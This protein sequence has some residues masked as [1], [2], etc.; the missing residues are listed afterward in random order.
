MKTFAGVVLGL[1]LMVAGAR[2]QNA[3]TATPTAPPGPTTGYQ[4][5]EQGADWRVWQQVTRSTN[6]VSRTNQL[7]QLVRSS[8]ITTRTNQAYVEMASGLHYWRNGRWNLSQE[9]INLLPQGGAAATNGQHQVYFPGDI[10]EGAIQVVTADGTVLNSRPLGISYDDGNNT[11]FLAVLTNSTGYL[12]SSNQVVYPNAFAGIKADLLYNYTR[13]GLTQDLILRQRP[14]APEDYQMDSRNTRLQLLTEFFNPPPPQVTPSVIP[15]QGGMVLTDQALDFGRMR[16]VPGGAFLMGSAAEDPGVRV[17]KNWVS[18]GGRQF[19]VEEVPVMA[20]AREL[21]Q[22]PLVAVQSR[23]PGGALWASSQRHWPAQRP[24]GRSS[25]PVLIARNDVKATPGLVLDYNFLNSNQNNYTFAG[26]STYYLSGNV[27][28]TGTSATFEGGAVLK[29]A[30]NVTLHVEAAV[31]WLASSYQPVVMVAK[32]DNSVGAVINGSTGNPG[33]NQYAA[34]ALFYDTTYLYARTNL[35][36]AHLRVA[37]AQTAVAFNGRTNHV[38]K[39]VQLVNCGIGVAATNATFALY[40]ALLWKVQTNFAGSSATGDIEQVTVDT[41]N[42]LNPNLTLNLTNCVLVGVANF[43][44]YTAQNVNT[45][46]GGAGVF[47]QVGAGW[48]YLAAGSGLQQAGTGTINTN[49]AKELA[50]LTTWPPLMVATNFAMSGSSSPTN[51][52]PQAFRDASP[53]PDLGYH[54]DPLDYVWTNKTVGTGVTLTLTNGVAIGY[55]GSYCL[56][57]GQQN[58]VVSQGTPNQMNHLVPYQ[59]V[60][61]QAQGAGNGLFAG[62]V[63]PVSIY[64]RF[65]D[66]PMLGGAGCSYF[67]GASY[68]DQSGWFD[69]MTLQDCSLRDGSLWLNPF[70]THET[71]GNNAAPTA[72]TLGLTNNLFQR[73]NVS[74]SREPNWVVNYE[75]GAS[76][77][78]GSGNLLTPF[79]LWLC[80][81]LFWNGTVGF[82]YFSGAMYGQTYPVSSPPGWYLLTGFAC[83][84]VLEL[85]PV[86]SIY[87]NLF[88]GVTPSLGVGADNSEGNINLVEANDAFY[89]SSSSWLANGYEMG[90]QTTNN[91]TVTSL[92]FATSFLGSWYLK[93]SSPNLINHGDVTADQRAMYHY[94]MQTNQIPETNSIVDIGFHYVATDQ[95]GNPLSNYWPGIPDYLTDVNGNGT[96]TSWVAWELLY[97]GQLGLNP[98][99]TDSAGNTLQSDYQNALANNI[100]AFTLGV[101]NNYVATSTTSVQLAITAG[102]P[103]YYAVSVDDTNFATDAAWRNFTSTNI[104]VNLGLTQ[105]WHDVWI[106]LV[107]PAP[108]ATVTWQW[109]RLKLDTTPPVLVVTNPVAGATVSVPLVQVS[110]YCPEPLGSLSYDLSNGLGLVTNQDAGVTSQYYDPV[111]STFTTN[112]FECVDVPLTNGVN[113]ITLHATDLAGNMSTTSFNVTLDYS[114]RT[115]P[116]VV[117]LYWPQNGSVLGNT[118][119]TWRG[120]VDDPTATVS[121]QLVDTNGNTNV[122]AGVVER[123]GN[124]WVENLPVTGGANTLTLTVTDSAGN[125]AQTN[126]VVYP[127]AVGLTLTLPDANQW[128]NPTVTVSGTISDAA[129]Y[130]V[131][132]NGV[133]ATYGD[134]GVSWTAANVPLPPGGTALVQARAIPNTDNGGQGVGGSGGGSA[135]N[136]NLG[137]PSSSQAKDIE[138]QADKQPRLYMSY[139]EED[140][141]GS[142][143][144]S[145]GDSTCTESYQLTATNGYTWRDMI[146]GS[147]GSEHLISQLNVDCAGGSNLPS[148]Y[149]TLASPPSPWESLLPGTNYVISIADQHASG[150]SVDQTNTYQASWQS[151]TPWE[152]C[153][154][155]LPVNSTVGWPYQWVGSGYPEDP[156]NTGNY[157]RHADATLTLQTG[158]KAVVQRKN[159]F[160]LNGTAAGVLDPHTYAEYYDEV[161][162]LYGGYGNYP[163]VGTVPLQTQSV[164]VDGVFLGSDG[165]LWRVYD[166]NDTRDVTPRVVN[167]DFYEFN[168]TQQ[169]YKLSINFGGQNV[170]DN[171]STVIVGQFINPVCGWV[172]GSGPTITNYSW[173]VPGDTFSNYLANANVGKL[174]IQLCLTNNEVDFY[175]KDAGSVQV[176][177]IINA[178]GQ[179][180]SAH[181]TFAVLRPNA[182]IQAI[183]NGSISIASINGHYQLCLGQQTPDNEGVL[184]GGTIDVPPNFT[185]NSEWI[186][187][188]SFSESEQTNDGTGVWYQLGPSD[189][190]LDTFYPYP[191]DTTFTMAT[192]FATATTDSPTSRPLDNYIA[193]NRQDNMQMWLMYK[194]NGGQWVPLRKVNWGWNGSGTLSGGGWHLSVNQPSPNV[195]ND[196]DTKQ[197]PEWTTNVTGYFPQP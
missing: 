179:S 114:T 168:L 73:C 57:L 20:V 75:G 26:N 137:N 148:L 172:G 133:Q 185:L 181:T 108:G 103:G 95:Y 163:F 69:Q 138:A 192:A 188:V 81:N 28:L 159:L 175:W 113:T 158:G 129:D 101:T 37:N 120:W 34:T 42:W 97:Y 70:N 187:L 68:L 121:A 15:A 186:Q 194:P 146:G 50:N 189:N 132:V 86:W 62:G 21:L 43:G 27:A 24:A 118:S 152:H 151:A 30:S 18:A 196:T 167:N 13:E 164:K 130:T 54:Y 52:G 67:D 31:T 55:Y 56:T 78:G 116:P 29:F 149:S 171:N 47:T 170:T 87:D 174:F 110:G 49:L 178:M 165:N 92:T 5:G 48:H 38:L 115:Q 74:L 197:P 11:V 66:L 94:T 53:T 145:F 160:Q 63:S 109:K 40:N 124:F 46:S 96:L 14:P 41:A 58:T 131:W 140:D 126:I 8:F 79:T 111:T 89:N 176:Q 19:L 25:K 84:N 76:S 183:P 105:G 59:A 157:H 127:S 77:G 144:G 100:I 143:G 190:A 106:G 3:G 9:Q 147:G 153:S 98:N 85:N 193:V 141:G 122:V 44:T 107:G 51:F 156:W 154:V 16:M 128:W 71:F 80:N 82:G 61:E 7:G 136:G 91:V 112:Y 72:A 184:F 99:A 2:A 195:G 36:L 10:Y 134:D 162:Y 93:S 4:E 161:S 17:G 22:L 155:T 139:Y 83:G 65:T 102:V 12:I 35:Q 64:L 180:I 173:T 39:D 33:T 23:S 177:C 166:D 123:N 88:D 32:D 60:Q 182:R 169:K 191:V 142:S 45:F 125:T 6:T 90:I 119:Y 104:I 117:N 1:I 135:S 150:Q